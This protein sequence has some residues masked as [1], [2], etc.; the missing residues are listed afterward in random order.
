MTARTH[1][2]PHFPGDLVDDTAGDYQRGLI[3]AFDPVDDMA[4]VLWFGTRCLGYLH[5]SWLRRAG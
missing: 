4:L 3:I 2:Y 1:R 5:V